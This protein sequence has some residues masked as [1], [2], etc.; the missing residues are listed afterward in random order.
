MFILTPLGHM[1]VDDFYCHIKL[2]TWTPSTFQ[3]E[4]KWYSRISFGISC[5]CAT[6]IWKFYIHLW[7]QILGFLSVSCYLKSMC[8]SRNIKQMIYRGV[9]WQ[10]LSMPNKIPG[11]TFCPQGVKKKFL[12][13]PISIAFHSLIFLVC[14]YLTVEQCVDLY[15]NII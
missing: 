15:F 6:R 12:K 10:V 9:I 3:R 7:D 13:N 5:R 11:D 4:D 1:R 8:V 14:Y 2:V